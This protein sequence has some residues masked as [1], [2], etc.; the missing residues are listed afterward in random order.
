MPR[1]GFSV[2]LEGA[3]PR[4]QEARGIEL[5]DLNMRLQY[6]IAKN[7]P[8]LLDL[9][10]NLLTLEPFRTL[11]RAARDPRAVLAPF[12]KPF[13]T[14]L[15]QN[16]ALRTGISCG[17]LRKLLLLHHLHQRIFFKLSAPI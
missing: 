12:E 17:S 1:K 7:S 14:V 6:G 13:F 5:G 3:G 15:D 10:D 16:P 8:V 4:N 11:G 2:L 9:G